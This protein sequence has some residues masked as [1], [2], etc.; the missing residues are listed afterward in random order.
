MPLLLKNLE[1]QHIISP[2]ELVVPVSRKPHRGNIVED[3]DHQ[4]AHK[5]ILLYAGNADFRYK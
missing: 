1:C 4:R 2:I 5:F 3:R